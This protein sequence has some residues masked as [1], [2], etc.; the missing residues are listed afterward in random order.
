MSWGGFQIYAK[1]QYG[2]A[3]YRTKKHETRALTSLRL[4]GFSLIGTKKQ[5]NLP[6]VMVISVHH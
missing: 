5:K 6:A 3:P 2:V 4:M 1:D